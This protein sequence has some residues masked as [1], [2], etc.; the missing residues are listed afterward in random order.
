[1]EKK[2]LHLESFKQALTST[3]KSISEIKDCDINF[4]QNSKNNSLKSVNLPELKKLEKF[5]DYSLIRAKADSEA[6]RLKYSDTRTFNLFKPRGNNAVKLYEIAERIRYEKL[7][8]DQFKGIKKNLLYNYRSKTD[9]S[10]LIEDVFE[11]YLRSLIFKTKE[12]KNSNAQI[13]KIKKNLE[14][15]FKKNREKINQSINNQGKF[16]KVISTIISNMDIE[17]KEVHE[18]ISEQNKEK[19]PLNKLENQKNEAKSQS[20]KEDNQTLDVNLSSVKDLSREEMQETKAEEIDASEGE[21]EGRPKNIFSNTTIKYK[22]FTQDYDEIIK[23]ED[24]ETE[25]E[26]IR[27]R[28]SLDQQLLQLKNFVSKLANKLQ[29]KLLAKQNRSW[30]FDLEEGILDTSKLTRVIIDPFNSLSLKK[31]KKLILKIL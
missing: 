17:D 30:N 1:M 9:K 15:N 27:L 13:K 29:R 11:D 20:E 22:V 3:I 14:T 4:G 12:I 19:D 5:E 26:L 21:T 28:S 8:C 7:G 23:A 18:D 10:N 16:N 31:K 25:T 6:L 24:L 2:D